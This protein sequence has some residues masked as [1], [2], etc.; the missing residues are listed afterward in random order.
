MTRSLSLGV[1]LSRKASSGL[2]HGTVDDFAQRPKS[3]RA[4]AS[5]LE[6]LQTWE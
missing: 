2:P 1:A 3:D 4:T 6:S 5:G